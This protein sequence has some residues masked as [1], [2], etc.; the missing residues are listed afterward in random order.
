MTRNPLTDFIEKG[1]LGSFEQAKMMSSTG[2]QFMR[3][4]TMPRAMVRLFEL[5]YPALKERIISGRSPW[6]SNIDY[7]KP[8]LDLEL[9]YQ[10]ERPKP[11]SER[12]LRP[13]WGVDPTAP[14][15]LALAKKLGAGE[16]SKRAFAED[17]F[18]HVKNRIKFAMEWPTGGAVATLKAGAATCLHKLSV[19]IALLRSNGIPARYRL[20]GAQIVKQLY[21]LQGVGADPLGAAIYDSVGYVFG[22]GCVELL[23]DGQWLPGDVTFEEELEVAMDVPITRLGMDPE[24]VWYFTVPGMVLR[25]EGLPVYM[26][27]VSLLFPMYRGMMDKINENFEKA[28]KLGRERLQAIGR[29]RYIEMKKKFY[30]PVLPPSVKRRE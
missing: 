10:G 7:T 22:H 30:V 26:D 1:Y 29:E 19:L 15:I 9:K 17:A 12:Y 4:F 13:T 14:E 25:V 20:V 28:R 2:F 23:L 27:G 8:D 16:K 18:A 5:N 3:A 21:D 6:S 24:G 11:S